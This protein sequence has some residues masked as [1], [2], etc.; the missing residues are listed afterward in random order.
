MP[1]QLP[2]F[3][4]SVDVKPTTILDIGL[5][6]VLIYFLFSLIR[7][8]RAVRLVIGATVLYGVYLLAQ[9]LGL[10]LVSQILQAGAYA[11]LFAL[12]VVFQPELRRALER[13][14]HVGSL[15]W[16][17]AP[18][19]QGAIEQVAAE[20]ARAASSLARDRHGALILIERETGLTDLAET[21]VMIHADLTAELL[22]TIFMPR[23]ALHDGAVIVR[24]DRILAAGA[25]IERLAESPAHAE[26]FGTR[27]RAA[28]GITE[29]TDALAVVVSEE[30]GSISLIERGRIVRN[31]DEDKLRVALVT[32]L[33]LG[34]SWRETGFGAAESP[35][36]GRGRL[37]IGRRP[38][39]RRRPPQ[40]MSVPSSP[41]PPANPSTG[42]A[43][44]RH[45]PA[46]AGGQGEHR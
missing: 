22:D 13:L 4:S 36:F 20:V 5:T 43:T 25:V 19:P 3:L 35:R 45:G 15:G 40:A 7:D 1:Q 16:L 21:G 27:H 18:G 39:P 28:F 34:T 14:G 23:S 11:A 17:L 29:E 38:G 33:K 41:P 42:T 24:R 6:A 10:Q 8:T 32:L 30:T 9:F 46:P 31:L 2:G 26:R 12:V 44:P 37:H